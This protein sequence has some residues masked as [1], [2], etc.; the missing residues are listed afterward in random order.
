[1]PGRF[2]SLIFAGILAAYVLSSSGCAAA[3]FIAGAGTAA[4]MVAVSQDKE[5]EGKKTEEK[6]EDIK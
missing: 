5:K 6:I 4:T 2:K 1:M 3:W